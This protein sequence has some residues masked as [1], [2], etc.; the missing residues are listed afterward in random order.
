MRNPSS[1][2][3]G[4]CKLCKILLYVRFMSD[5]FTYNKIKFCLPEKLTFR[6]KVGVNPMF[7]QKDGFEG[8]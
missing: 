2:G 5:L 3:S 4:S 6:N 8:D 7:K 1:P